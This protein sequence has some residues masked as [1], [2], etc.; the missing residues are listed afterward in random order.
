MKYA[1]HLAK[2]QPALRRAT[3][4]LAVAV[5]V[6]EMSGLAHAQ[7]STQDAPQAEAVQSVVVTGSLIRRVATEGATPVTTI[8]ATELESRGHTELKDLVLEQP[9]SLS[10]GTNSGAAGPMTNLRGL[11]PMRTL[12]L[13]NGRRLANEPLQDQYVSVNVIPRMALDRVETLSGGAASTYGADAIGGVQNYWTKRGYEGV[14]LKGEYARPEESGGGKTTSF[15]A[16][17]GIGNLARDGWNAYIAVDHQKKTPLFQG[18]R[19][20]QHDPDVLRS[21]GLGLLPDARNP[22]PTANFGFARNA[23]SN[24]NPTYANGCVDPYS[25]PTLGNQSANTPAVYAPGCYRNPL[26][27]NAVTD[28]SEI[29]T[30]AARSSFNIP[31]GHKI[32]IDVLHSKFTVQK[33]RGM[34][35]PGG[36]NPFTTYSLPS[37]SRFYPGNGITPA[38]QVVGNNDGTN[39]P[40]MY[41]DPTRTPGTVSNLNMNGRTLYFQWG[42]AELGS[43]Y[44]NDEQTNDRV[45]LTAEGEVLGWD[46]RAGVNWGMSKRDT[47]VGGGYILYSKAQEGFNNGTLNPF[48][49]QDEAGAEYLRSIE[50]NNYTYRLNKAYNKSVDVT[51]SKALMSLKGGDLTLALAAELRR[52]AARTYDAPLDFVYKKADGSYNLDAAGNVLQHDLVGETPQGVGKRLSRDISSLLAEVEAPITETIS[53]NGAVRADHYDDLKQTTVNP[54]LAGSWRPM[55]SL[56]LRSSLSTGFRAPSIMDIQNPT[57]EVRTID[58]DD[59]V[60]CPSAQPTVAGSGTPVAGYTA[61]QVCNVS[62]EYW[63]KSPNNSFLKPEKSRGFSFGFAYEP[64][65][66]LSVTVDYWGLKIKDV[67]GAVTIAEVQQ[68]PAKYEEFILRRADGT[69]DHIVASQAN[70]GMSRIRGADV[71]ASYRFPVTSYGTFDAKLDGTWY[72]KYEFQSEKD[73]PWHTNIG[74]ITNDGRFGGAGPNAGLAGM[75]QINPRWKHTASFSWGQGPWRATLSQ[76]YQRGVTDLTPRVGSTLTKVDDYSQFNVNLRYTGIKNTTVS[77]GVNNITEEWPPL[78]ANS[79]YSGGYVTSMADML[80]RVFRLSVEYKF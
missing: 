66:N 75:P 68:D 27:Y 6:C 16:I 5:A 47:K 9:Q 80:G 22:S 12:T 79:V 36:T 4:A 65:R 71:S 76:R 17:A 29:Q 37:S 53:I 10:L 20:E 46:Y 55:E 77:L 1:P 32:D 54:R 51:L 40:A 48:G 63:T 21:L 2:R 69:I 14:T 42:P 64:I 25:R 7:S 19:A 30:I 34:Q 50:A 60:L 59:P 58:M 38:V 39:A 61:D 28:G 67:L 44:R 11:G 18:E 70:R 72:H 33:F 62:T 15:G 3:M 24:Y 49:L 45:V 41:I 73:G 52:D 8:K 13:L 35:V 57:A 56:L 31:G 78:T 43:A 74:I 23:N 26:F